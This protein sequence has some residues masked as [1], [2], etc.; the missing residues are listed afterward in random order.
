MA[1]VFPFSPNW[2]HLGTKTLVQFGQM[3][4]STFSLQQ[5]NVD[6]GNGTVKTYLSNGNVWLKLGTGTG[7]LGVV[8]T[9]ADLA[10]TFTDAGVGCSAY[11]GASPSSY[12]RYEL[13]AEPSSDP[14]NWQAV[15]RLIDGT[16]FTVYFPTGLVPR[17]ALIQVGAGDRIQVTVNSDAGNVLMPVMIAAD[18]PYM[19]SVHDVLGE[20]QPSGMSFQRLTGAS[21]ASQ[22]SLE[23]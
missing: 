4:A 16:L 7:F 18:T 23:Y 2:G 20:V 8:A 5:V 19:L 13:K 17:L 1:T 9:A 15:Q 6:Q 22:F 12:A 3:S 11:V 10:T 21:G 14:L